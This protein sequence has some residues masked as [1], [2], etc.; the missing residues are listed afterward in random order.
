MKMKKNN[1]ILEKINNIIK[2]ISNNDKL[3]VIFTTISTVCCHLAFFV[4]RWAN[5]DDFHEIMGQVNMIGSGRWMPGTL[6]SSNFLAP[7]VLFVIVIIFLSLM[8]VM[9]NR[10]F[11]IEKKKYI[12]IISLLLSS[13]PILAF[14]YGYGFMVERY[15]LGMFFAVLSVYLTDK[16]K[17]GFILGAISLAVT[18][19]YYQS[20]ISISIGL[21]IL[22]LIFKLFNIDNIKEA[23]LTISKF[24]FMGL[25]GVILYMLIVRI[26]CFIT[27]ISL[28]DYKGINN[29]GSL[30]PF[31]KMPFLLKRT[32]I[33]FNDFFLSK[34]FIH[35]LFYG[36]IAQLL[37]YLANI[38][39]VF[40]VLIKEKIYKHKSILFIILLFIILVPLGF[41]IVDFMAVESE[42]SSLN[43]YQFVFIFIFPFCLLNYIENKYE[44]KNMFVLMDSFYLICGLAL[45]WNNFVVT[46][47]YYLKINDYYTS[48]V[49][50]TNRVYNRIEQIPEFNGNTKVMVGNKKG[51]YNDQRTFR[52]YFDVITYDQGLWDRFIGYAP[53]PTGTDFKFHYLVE[54]IIGVHLYSVSPEVFEIIYSSDEYENME[55]WP[56]DGC[57]KYIDGNLVVKIS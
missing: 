24:L 43:I 50:L 6:L 57:M 13:F 3:A 18:M 20:Y 25:C 42:T 45:I 49:Q 38:I 1:F 21:V 9:I 35:P 10:M 14:G 7:I 29:M 22:L 28:L 36:R 47:I 16:Y 15:T 26:V 54:N 19:G 44:F 41:N 56:K 17:F 27:G 37:L 34:K 4:N 30:P 39:L 46:N 52:P 53:R 51:I 33:D 55:S 12:F 31:N 2:G 48:T 40:I 23:I 32:Y 8:S 5:E 11:K